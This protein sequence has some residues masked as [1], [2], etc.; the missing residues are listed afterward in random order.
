MWEQVRETGYWKGEI[1]NRRKDGTVFPE[2][3]TITTLSDGAGHICNYIA[4]FSDATSYK[5]K[6]ER[7]Q[8]M[9]HHDALTGLPN[10]T[11]MQDRL[12]MAIAKAKRIHGNVAILFIDLDRFKVIN[13]SLG[14]HY[15]DMLLKIVAKRLTSVVRA[16]DTVC[17]QGGDEFIIIL[18]EVESIGDVAHIAEK[19]LKSVSEECRVDNEVLKVSP[20][21]GI[22][23]FPDDGNDIAT[24]IKNADTAMYHAKESGRANFQFFTERLNQILLQRME[25]ERELSM[26]IQREQ[27]T[28]HYQPQIDLTSGQVTGAEALLRWN[29]PTLGSV[30]PMK[31]IQIAEEAGLIGE[32][33]VWVLGQVFAFAARWNRHPQL[34]QLVFSANVSARQLEDTAFAESV[35]RL[36]NESGFPADR[37]ELEITETA[38]ME[39]IQRSIPPLT[40]LKSLG[41]K[42]AIDDFGTGYSSL[43]YLKRLPIS[44]LKIDRS[45]ISD[46]PEDKSD[47]RITHAIINLAQS[48]NLEVIAEGVESEEQTRFLIEAGCLNAQGFFYARPLAEHDF[49]AFVEQSSVTNSPS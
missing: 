5:E 25:I 1:W 32:I 37:L 39:D 44:R 35:E 8:H 28:L 47:E 3:L 27:L 13:D 36:L 34:S 15:G 26:A 31:F 48:L 21:I 23:L 41:V 19:L 6:E 24:L 11:L 40:E 43:N 30:S 7:I 14:H 18:P 42:I 10:R 49:V 12:E 16:S 38:I 22:S 46:I 45:F 9:A 17:R 20:S 33:G 4:I 29:H 2:W